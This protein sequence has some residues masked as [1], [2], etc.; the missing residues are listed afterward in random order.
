MSRKAKFNNLAS[1]QFARLLAVKLSFAGEKDSIIQ[2]RKD[3][4]IN[5]EMCAR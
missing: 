5:K 2:K 1:V 4:V 3:L